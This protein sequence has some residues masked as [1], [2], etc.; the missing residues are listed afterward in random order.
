MPHDPGEH[1]LVAREGSHSLPG[2]R[3]FRSARKKIT[4]G[5]MASGGKNLYVVLKR[6]FFAIGAEGAFRRRRRTPLPRDGHKLAFFFL[7]LAGSRL[8]GWRK[9][10]EVRKGAYENFAFQF[11]RYGAHPLRGPCTSEEIRKAYGACVP[12][13]NLARRSRTEIVGFRPTDAK[14]PRS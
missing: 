4:A 3:L 7:P 8:S 14:S 12:C 5:D 13:A 2:E 9:G 10:S 11:E 6:H 1:S